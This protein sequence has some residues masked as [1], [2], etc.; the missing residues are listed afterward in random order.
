MKNKTTVNKNP[1]T[2]LD[3]SSKPLPIR[4]FN[5]LERTLEKRGKSIVDLSAD[6]LMEK[7]VRKT[8]LSDWGDDESFRI[9]LKLLLES[10]REE[11]ILNP[12]GRWFFSKRTIGLLCNRLCIQDEIKRHPEILNEEIRKP[13][14]IVSQPRTGS[15]LLH[16]LL[17][18]D[19]SSRYLRLWETLAPSLHPRHL[20]KKTDPRIA[21]TKRWI[22]L[23]ERFGKR[24]A[25]EI[26]VAH[27]M[28]AEGPEECFPLL[29][30]SFPCEIPFTIFGFS[31]YKNW[32]KR[33]DNSPTYHYYKQIL[34]LLQWHLRG[35]HWVLKAAFHL[36]FLGALLTVFPDACI[37]QI[38]RDPLK[39]VPS[40]CSLMAPGARIAFNNHIDL[41]SA[42]DKMAGRCAKV[43]DHTINVRKSADPAQFY[44]VYYKDLMKDP[45][46][47]V[48]DIYQYFGYN[49]DES[50]DERIR[51][52]LAK[53]RQYKKG[54]HRYSLEQF[55]L[56]KEMINRK[57]ANY[58]RLYNVPKESL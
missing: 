11:P 18:Q 55:G 46:G 48:R 34:Q 39:V 3:P 57:F 53:N 10:Y 14:F 49:Y 47:T 8:G 27:P 15:T 52:W 41:K 23:M 28:F 38:H 44:D 31:Q 50:M 40:F 36:A 17:S 19:P 32:L 29:E 42:G 6:S 5:W 9:P 58:N 25:P 43:L 12:F 45:V 24:F 30:L 56:D 4:I 51:N 1:Y 2:A 7:A 22:W 54:V 33:Q 13:L 20:T 35:D 21:G 37:V 26:V 16:N